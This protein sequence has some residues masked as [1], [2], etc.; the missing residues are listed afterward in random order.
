M[1]E[2]DMPRPAA[3]P[4]APV[5]VLVWAKLDGAD[6]ATSPIPSIAA[7]AVRINRLLVI[8]ALHSSAIKAQTSKREDGS[9]AP[10]ESNRK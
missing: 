4:P 9:N 7:A 10:A 2:A 3:L 1:V 8:A 6:P 5:E